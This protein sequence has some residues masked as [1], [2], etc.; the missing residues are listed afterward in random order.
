[1]SAV[2]AVAAFPAA[3]LAVWV[4]LRS[5]VSQG[6]EGVPDQSRWRAATTPLVGGVGIYLG[7]SVGIWLAVLLGPL[8]AD[9]QLVGVFAGASVLFLAGLADDLRALPPLVKLAAQLAGAAIACVG[10][11]ILAATTK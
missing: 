10:A 7:L 3:L 8:T 6:L 4:L 11:A 1:M 2:A 9:R 5:R